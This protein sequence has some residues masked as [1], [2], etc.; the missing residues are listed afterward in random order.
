M[1]KK[2]LDFAF[3]LGSAVHDVKNSLGLLMNSLDDFV[4]ANPPKNDSDTKAVVALNYEASRINNDLMQL[5][6]IYR[7]DTDRLFLA[8]EEHFVEEF[9]DDELLVHQTLL[10][11][12]Q[13]DVELDCEEDLCWYFD[14]ALLKSVINNVLVNTIR[15]TKDKVRIAAEAKGDYLCITIEDNGRGYPDD[16]QKDPA[17]YLSRIDFNT[18]STGLGLYFSGKVADMH[19]NQDNK[20]YIEVDNKSSLGGGAFRIYLP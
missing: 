18:G 6:S 15:Y 3:I 2:P 4:T 8:V 10:Q 20:G 7:L 5:L 14:S 17:E 9:L 13:L 11:M 16:L 12:K 1:S 19:Q